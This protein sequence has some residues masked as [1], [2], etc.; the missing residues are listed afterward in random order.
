MPKRFSI[1]ISLRTK[2][3]IF[4]GAIISVF[5]IFVLYRTAVF[6]ERMILKQAEQQAKAS[7]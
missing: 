2:F 6:D 3:V 1:S 5:Y 4:I 7:S